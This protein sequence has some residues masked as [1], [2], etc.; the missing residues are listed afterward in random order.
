MKFGIRIADLSA[1]LR[2]TFLVTTFSSIFP[3]EQMSK[4]IGAGPRIGV[5]GSTPLGGPWSLDWLAG[6]ALLVGKR[7][8]DISLTHISTTVVINTELSRSSTA[9]VPNLDAA[10]GLSYWLNPA[11]KVTASYRF[12]GYFGR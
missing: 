8:L 5:E 10:L 7:T 9:A 4:F 3:F 11:L 12:D 2:C 6:A 1:R